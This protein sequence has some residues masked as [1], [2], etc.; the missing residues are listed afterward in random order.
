MNALREDG[1][2]NSLVSRT[3]AGII[4]G[5]GRGAAERL[6]AGLGTVGARAAGSA[7]VTTADIGIAP[8]LTDAV[9]AGVSRDTPCEAI[10]V[11]PLTRSPGTDLA[12]DRPTAGLRT[13]VLRVTALAGLGTS[14]PDSVGITLAAVGVSPSTAGDS[15]GP[16]ARITR[17]EQASLDWRCVA[18]TLESTLSLPRPTSTKTAS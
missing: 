13:V 4:S 2:F 18:R 3:F 8:G 10:I 14:E 17:A 5:D 16:A 12:T 6:A 1:A 15:G 7:I 11:L 9:G